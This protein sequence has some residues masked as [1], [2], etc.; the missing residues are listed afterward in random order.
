MPIVRDEKFDIRVHATINCPDEEIE[1]EYEH[2]SS[3]DIL[4][5]NI[6]QEYPNCTSM[7]LAIT[8]HGPWKAN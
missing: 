8:D 6:N 2:V 4:I 7:V 1:R 3:L 5:E